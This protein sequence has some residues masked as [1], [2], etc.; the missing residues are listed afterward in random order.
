MKEKRVKIECTKG[1]IIGLLGCVKMAQQHAYEEY[2]EQKRGSKSAYLF[3]SHWI[4]RLNEAYE[5]A[6]EKEAN[7]K[8]K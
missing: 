2:K 6:K 3:A 1:E 7:G 8:N 5:K 4:Q